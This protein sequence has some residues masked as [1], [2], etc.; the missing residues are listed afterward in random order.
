MDQKKSKYEK[1]FL[2]RYGKLKD[3][4]LKI[5]GPGDGGSLMMHSSG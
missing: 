3:I 4:T 1:P 2:A 5:R